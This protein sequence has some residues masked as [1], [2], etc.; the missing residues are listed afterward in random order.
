MLRKILLSLLGLILV[1]GS[2]LLSIY[3]IESKKNPEPKES[4]IVKTVFVDTVQN[5]T[6]PMII[7]SSGT[8]IAKRRV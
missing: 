3:L 1:V 7:E 6:V 8:L 5:S 2:I 4:K